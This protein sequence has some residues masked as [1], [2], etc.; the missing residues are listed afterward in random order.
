MKGGEN[1]KKIDMIGKKFGKLTVIE[2]CDERSRQH[3]I[4]YKCQCDCGKMVDT[5]GA[6]LRN[7]RAK[8]CGCLR[9]SNHPKIHEKSGTRL[10]RIWQNMKQRCYNSSNKDYKDY[11]VRGIKICDEWLNDFQSFYDWSMNNNYNNALT[12]DRI[13]VNGNYEPDNCCWST[14]KQQTENR[15]NNIY[16]TYH[17][18]T[19]T[20]SQWAKDLGVSYVKLYKRHYRGYT[21]SECIVGKETIENV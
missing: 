10:Y 17:G 15:R 8:S 2:E 12:I 14:R 4:V 21:D 16:L 6:E 9:V 20:I 3:K 11:G 19:Q 5:I 7:G 18:K 1:T 13:D